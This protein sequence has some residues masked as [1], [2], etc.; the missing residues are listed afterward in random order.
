MDYQ[1]FLTHLQSSRNYNGQV[2]R[3]EKI[4]ARDAAFD[5]L[6]SPLPEMLERALLGVEDESQNPNKNNPI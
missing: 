1:Q 4:P 6:S 3:I 2:A 5:E